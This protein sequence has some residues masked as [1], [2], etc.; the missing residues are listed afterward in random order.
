[1]VLAEWIGGKAGLKKCA[2]KH[3]LFLI[4]NTNRVTGLCLRQSSRATIKI[5]VAIPKTVFAFFA[6]EPFAK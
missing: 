6:P 1:M 2:T 5:C 3:L 4:A